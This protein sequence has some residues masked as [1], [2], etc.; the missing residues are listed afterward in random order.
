MPT[1]EQL[2]QIVNGTVGEARIPGI[3]VATKTNLA[4]VGEAILEAGHANAF[5][6]VLIDKVGMTIVRDKIFKNPLSKLKKGTM[7][8]GYIVE[9][10]AAN[11]AVTSNYD[12]ASTTGLLQ[13]VK[14]DVKAVYH[15]LN[16]KKYEKVSIAEDDIKTAFK[17][18][19]AFEAFLGMIVNTLYSGMELYD[20]DA[21]KKTIETAVTN[22]DVVS[23]VLAAPTGTQDSTDAF[24]LAIKNKISAFKFPSTAFNKYADLSVGE[25]PYKTWT[26]VEDQILIV[27]SDILNTIDVYSLARAFNLTYEQFMAQVVEVDYIDEAKNINAVLCDKSAFVYYDKLRKTTSFYNAESLVWTYWNHHWSLFDIN[28]LANCVVFTQ[29]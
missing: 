27:R 4:S 11:P 20:F 5:L 21:L 29:A 9:S 2:T 6:N 15:A 1:I 8:M 25:T 14:P 18:Y 23:E 12:N 13:Q 7:P 10:L 3:P 24:I 26:P 22:G 28:P 16:S 19:S 17:D